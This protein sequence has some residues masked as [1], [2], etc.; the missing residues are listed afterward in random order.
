MRILIDT[1]ILLWAAAGEVP[2]WIIGYI[3]DER[4]TLLFSPVSIWE[5]AIKQGL[6]RDDFDIDPASLYSELI[7]SGYEEL[8]ITGR[9]ALQVSYLPSIH[10][11]PFDRLLIAQASYEGITFLTADRN[12]SRYP[13]PIIYVGS[14]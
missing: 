5:I 7:F 1:C 6:G 14:V 4:N 9:H 8:P 2:V 3:E 11:D 13:G 12:L 10:K